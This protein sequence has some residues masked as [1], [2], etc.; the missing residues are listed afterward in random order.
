MSASIW[1]A[2]CS[3]ACETSVLFLP[4]PA[5]GLSFA[6]WG[7][8]MQCMVLCGLDRPSSELILMSNRVISLRPRYLN[9]DP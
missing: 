8:G 7:R 4:L 6:A 5:S 3:H 9:R 1:S 2:R